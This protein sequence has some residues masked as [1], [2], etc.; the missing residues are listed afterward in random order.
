MKRQLRTL[1]AAAVAASILATTGQSASAGPAT[2]TDTP[3]AKAPAAKAPAAKAP[4]P[5]APAP[6]ATGATPR[7]D[8]DTRPR[9]RIAAADRAHVLG[10]AWQ[11][12]SDRLWTTSGD[13]TGLH[14]LV[15]EADDGYTWRTVATLVEPGIASDMWIGNACLTASG[16]RAV[17]V[18]EPRHFANRQHLFDRGA[19]AAV[20]D[21][22][23]GAVT[24][25]DATVS[26]AYYN[27]GCGAGETAAL[28]QGGAVDLGKTAINLLDTG[29]RKVTSRVEVTGQVT[30]AVPYAGKIAASDGKRIVSIDPSGKTETLTPTGRAVAHLTA[31]ASGGLT[32]LEE[33]DAHT[34]VVRHLDKGT[35]HVRELGRGPLADVSLARGTGGRVFITGRPSRVGTLPAGVNAIDAPADAEISS[36]GAAVLTTPDRAPA[37]AGATPDAAVP[38]GRRA[39]F[40]ETGRSA[41]FVVDPDARISA[42]NATGSA[43]T[44]QLKAAGLAAAGSATDPTEADRYCG[45]SRN[46]LTA[47]VEQPHWH[48]IAW[49]AQLAVRGNLTLTRPANWKGTNLPAWSPQT[50][51]GFTHLNGGGYIP[52]QI[53]LGILAQESNLWQASYHALEGVPG[54]PLVGAY[55]GIRSGWAINWDA[56]DCGYGVA[57][58]T[59]GMRI[60][61]HPKPGEHLRPPNEQKA[62]AVDYATNIAAGVNILTEKWNTTRGLGMTVNNGDPARPENWFAAVWAYNS[63]LNPQA[64]TGNTTGCTPGPSCTDS[65]GAWGL[66]WGNNPANPDYPYNRHAFLDGPNG[67]GVGG[68]AD[69]ATPQKWPYPEKI[70]GWAAYP[71]VKYDYRDNSYEAAF[72]QA[73]WGGADNDEANLHRTQG[74]KPPLNTFC[75]AA[76]NC[77]TAGGQPNGQGKC[78]YSD[79]HCWWHWSASWKGDCSTCGNENPNPNYTPGSAEP[80]RGTHFPPVCAQNT[81]LPSGALVIDD[82]P[83]SA[84]VVRSDECNGGTVANSGTFGLNFSGNG[85]TYPSKLDFHQ[86]GTGLNGHLWFSHEESIALNAS[87][88]VGVTGTWTLGRS[89]NQ[90]AKVWVHLPYEVGETQQ[91]HYRIDRGAGAPSGTRYKWR[92]IGQDRGHSEWVSLGAFQIQGTPSVSLSNITRTSE[93][94]QGVD[95][96]VWDAVAFEP[97]TAKPKDFVVAMGD[98]FSSGEG[99]VNDPRTDYYVDSNHNTQTGNDAFRNGCH[100]SPYAWA[101]QAT[102]AGDSRTIGARTDARDTTMDYHMVACSGTQSEHMLPSLSNPIT[103]AQNPDP[104]T[105]GAWTN[106]WG[107]TA[108]SN[109]GS[110]REV[111]QMDSGF[112]DEN[113]TLVTISVGGNDVGWSGVV[114][115]CLLVPAVPDCKY[116]SNDDGQ[117]LMNYV[118]E[119]MEQKLRPTLV[120]MIRAIHTMA[121]NATIVLMGYPKLISGAGNCIIVPVPFL[122]DLTVGEVDWMNQA[123][124]EMAALEQEIADTARR[125]GTNVW[126]ANPV[127]QFEGHGVCGSPEGLHDADFITGSGEKD[128]ALMASSS[129]HPNMYGG[130]LYRDT[131]NSTLRAAGK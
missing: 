117:L 7:V 70:M 48:Q 106:G 91:A 121:S 96:V 80:A 109:G 82:V 39:T 122:V 26:I 64:S 67:G 37:E 47:Q 60:A 28:T 31:D 30:S 92:V 11:K 84:P 111:T 76:N 126:F 105:G 3:A 14:L 85:T 59:D 130:E 46:D 44:P 62:I 89:L 58:V 119:V 5:K 27:P 131:L 113:T 99:V 63:G 45:V 71:I 22:D 101:R 124:V 53:M 1:L 16:K 56:A 6:K 23:T 25:L 75:S 97:L 120:T 36:T 69:A 52:A 129:L 17:V 81:S 19:F 2:I 88:H 100:R 41:D 65:R 118:P 73:W 29:T 93:A 107:Q 61:G 98:S 102:L 74:I 34:T 83:S 4:A 123:A 90:W 103:G 95:N 49:A 68:Q 77:T 79:Y 110:M 42:K 43:P 21:I 72:N 24:K 78:G 20:V 127:P 128:D 54:N 87:S 10:A 51:E 50:M 114:T 8:D 13:S 115:K 38:V 33:T 9:D 32:Y 125:N 94:T 55:Y 116:K 104:T 12:S 35:T 15:A 18:Y 108:S 112:L 57:Q 86:L 66:G 40:R